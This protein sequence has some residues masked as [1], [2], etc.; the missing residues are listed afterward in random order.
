ME[1][2]RSDRGFLMTLSFVCMVLLLYTLSLS[3]IRNSPFSIH[4]LLF[5]AYPYWI[6][7]GRF[8]PQSSVAC[9]AQ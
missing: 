5:T 8:L 2:G 9:S 7:H 3:R 4:F 1:K 6:G